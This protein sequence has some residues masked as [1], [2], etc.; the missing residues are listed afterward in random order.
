MTASPPACD[1]WS[2]MITHP[3]DS[4]RPGVARVAELDA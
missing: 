3:C 1:Y 4:S 2:R